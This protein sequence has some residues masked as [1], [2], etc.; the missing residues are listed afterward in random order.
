M[1]NIT[2]A[3]ELKNAIQLLEVEQAIKGQLVKEQFFI[4]YESLRPVNLLR[5]TIK[6]VV[7]SPNLYGNIIDTAIGMAT[8]YLSKKMVIGSSGNIFKKL[9]G[10]ALQV[11]VTNVVSQHTDIIR[12]FGQY[13]FQ[14]I[15]NTKDHNKQENGE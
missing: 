13:I 12:S 2:S 7:T 9:I 3:V 4:T 11:G 10:S 5:S 15:F 1:Q 14:H 8:G 6:E